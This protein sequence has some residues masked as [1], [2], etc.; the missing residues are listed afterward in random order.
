VEYKDGALSGTPTQEGVFHISF[1]AS[2]EAGFSTQSFTLTVD[3]PPAITSADEATFSYGAPGTFTVSASGTPTPTIVKWGNLPAGVS[4]SDGVLSGTP[5]QIGTFE[6]TFTASNGIGANSIQ[7]FT[8]TVLGL[9]VTTTSLPAATIGTPYS[10]Q[11]E[12]IGGVA[13]YKWKL[14]SGSLPKGFKLSGAGVLSGDAT[15]NK[16]PSG[17]SY[18]ITVQATDHTAKV[19]QTASASLTLRIG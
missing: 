14:T 18:A 1:T 10:Q 8:L 12:A 15:A 19:H 6:V 5:T 3:A 16:D 13:P 17:S 9:H 7:Q 11:L 2:N 4:Y